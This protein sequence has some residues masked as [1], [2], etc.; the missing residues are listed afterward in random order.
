MQQVAQRIFSGGMAAWCR[1][2]AEY[3]TG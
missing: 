1:H 2:A 3:N